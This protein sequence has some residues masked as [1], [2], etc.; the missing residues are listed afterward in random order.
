[1]EQPW[2]CGF[3]R[4]CVLDVLSCHKLALRCLPGRLKTGVRLPAGLINR[5]TTPVAYMCTPL[6]VNRNWLSNA[7]PRP[8]TMTP[9]SI[10]YTATCSASLGRNQRLQP[11][12]TSP[13]C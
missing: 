3:G 10:A 2:L 9:S 4:R 7:S 11:W 8:S 12:R 5:R 6:Q 13:M 1:M